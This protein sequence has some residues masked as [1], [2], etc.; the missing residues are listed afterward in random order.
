MSQKLGFNVYFRKIGYAYSECD[1]ANKVYEYTLGPK[2]RVAD[3]VAQASEAARI[4]ENSPFQTVV[5]VPLVVREL[6]LVVCRGISSYVNLS[7]FESCWNT[8]QLY[9]TVVR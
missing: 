9:F 6:L 5:R 1:I 4:L 3:L 7:N 8:M 2:A